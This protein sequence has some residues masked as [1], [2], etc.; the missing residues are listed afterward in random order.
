MKVILDTSVWIEF[1]KGNPDYSKKVYELLS[2]DNVI[3]L[4]CVFGELLQGVKS[5]IEKNKIH[6]LWQV[7]GRLPETDLMIDA[8]IF[9]FENKLI[10]KGVGLIDACLIYSAKSNNVSIWTLD[11]KLNAALPIELVYS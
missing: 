2:E 4:S 5:Q 3:G 7:I 10:N 1:L 11:K 9:S 6:Q 8:G